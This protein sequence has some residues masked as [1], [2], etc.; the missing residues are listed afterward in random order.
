MNDTASNRP[1]RV[2][3]VSPGARSGLLGEVIGSDAIAAYDENET[4]AA[5]GEPI[6]GYQFTDPDGTA[7]TGEAINADTGVVTQPGDPLPPILG[8]LD[9]TG[10]TV[11]AG[12]TEERIE[13]AAA[14]ETDEERALRADAI[15]Q[16]EEAAGQDDETREWLA[17]ALATAVASGPEAPG[18]DEGEPQDV[19]EVPADLTTVDALLEWV[20]AADD[21]EEAHVRATAVLNAEQARD[22][23]PRK[24]LVEPLQALLTA[25]EPSGE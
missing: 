9:V 7:G 15:W 11:P 18:E 5:Q 12:T 24:T 17:R 8:T 22:G 4:L 13:W 20:H 6:T 3:N 21:N 19:L 25:V 14:G 10:V 23:E 16:Y 2:P 1:V